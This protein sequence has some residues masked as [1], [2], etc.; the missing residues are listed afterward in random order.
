MKNQIGAGV[1]ILILKDNKVLLGKRH[2]DPEKA[3]SLLHGAGTWTMPG[4]KLDFQESFEQGAIRETLEESGI[5]ITKIKVI[6]VNN[7]KVPTAHFITIG[8]LAEE[9]EGKPQVLE[10]DKIIKWEFFPLDK[11]PEPMYL[12]SKKILENYKQKKFY[13]SK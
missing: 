3:T 11:L 7:D 10:P 6:C 5:K 9:Y 4:G 1:G 8:L 2:G 13:I 12:P